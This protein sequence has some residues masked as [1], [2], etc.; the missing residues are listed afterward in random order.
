MAREDIIEEVR[1]WGLV[2]AQVGAWF[3]LPLFAC[4]LAA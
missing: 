1:F 2:L 3:G 4:W